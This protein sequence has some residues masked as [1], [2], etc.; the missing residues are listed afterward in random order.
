MV[1]DKEDER[2]RILAL[3]NLTPEQQHVV[4][5]YIR[6]KMWKLRHWEQRSGDSNIYIEYLNATIYL[7][8]LIDKEIEKI[9]K[10][11][12]KQQQQKRK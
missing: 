4:D 8:N 7:D 10:R 12:S 5:I 11:H 3:A 1:A 9:R 6:E 2:E